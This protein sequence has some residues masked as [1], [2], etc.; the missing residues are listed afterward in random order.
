MNHGTNAE[1]FNS[2]CRNRYSDSCS[3]CPACAMDCFLFPS[4]KNPRTVRGTIHQPI[5]NVPCL[6]GRRAHPIPGLAS[7]VWENCTHRA[8][9]CFRGR[10][11][12][13]SDHIRDHQQILQGKLSCIPRSP[14]GILL[15]LSMHSHR[16]TTPLA[17]SF[18]VDRS[19]TSSTREI[20]NFIV[21]STQPE[22]RHIL[23]AHCV[24]WK[25]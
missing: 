17:E 20:Q 1:P 24:K 9:N 7:K 13:H 8:Q 16:S 22:H 21:D 19:P 4:T 11:R 23:S 6:H 18:K 10:H 15:K 14:K 2:S 5:L 25:S 12:S 3:H